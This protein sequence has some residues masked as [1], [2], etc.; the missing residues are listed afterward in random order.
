MSANLRLGWEPENI[1]PLSIIFEKMKLHA[2]GRGGVTILKNGTLLFIKESEDDIASARKALDE[3]KFL[4]DFRILRLKEGDC[5][6]VLHGAVAV[7]VGDDEF[8]TMKSQI[9]NRILELKFPSEELIAP[10]N[11]PET[12]MLLGLYGRGKLQRDIY[13]F[14][15]HARVR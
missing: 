15:V 13:N 4:T 14:E 9:E 12:N 2:E 10:R 11:S 5:L 8:E 1:T 6:V 3:A 7:Y